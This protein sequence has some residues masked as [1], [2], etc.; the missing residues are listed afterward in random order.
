MLLLLINVGNFSQDKLS[1]PLLILCLIAGIG[2]VMAVDKPSLFPSSN[3]SASQ[4]SPNAAQPTETKEECQDTV[5]HLALIGK[6]CEGVTAGRNVSSIVKLLNDHGFNDLGLVDASSAIEFLRQSGIEKCLRGKYVCTAA[7]GYKVKCRDVFGNKKFLPESYIGKSL[8]DEC[9]Y[10]AQGYYSAYPSKLQAKCTKVFL[11][12]VKDK[13]K[14]CNDMCKKI[15]KSCV[16]YGSYG[17]LDCSRYFTVPHCCWDPKKECKYFK[18]EEKWETMYE[19]DVNIFG[20]CES[21]P[22][23]SSC[24]YKF[25]TAGDPVM[26][27]IQTEGGYG[28]ENRPCVDKAEYEAKGKNCTKTTLIPDGSAYCYCY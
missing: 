13:S 25:G 8:L 2:L 1:A 6:S 20:F 22:A 11:N 17:S 4:T 9:C 7:T 5:A 16:G 12:V 26:V 15:G 10:Q 19:Q 27:T 28:R 14:S 3:R 24:S 18:A 23:S 21:S